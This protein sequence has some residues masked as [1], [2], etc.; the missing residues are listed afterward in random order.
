MKNILYCPKFANS[1]IQVATAHLTALQKQVPNGYRSPLSL[2]PLPP[3]YRQK[4]RKNEKCVYCKRWLNNPTVILICWRFQR[5]D[6]GLAGARSWLY[7]SSTFR[8]NTERTRKAAF[9]CVCVHASV[10]VYV[11]VC[12]CLLPST[13]LRF[14]GFTLTHTGNKKKK[15]TGLV[16]FQKKYDLYQ[17]LHESLSIATTKL[18]ILQQQVAMCC[19]T[20][21]A[22]FGGIG[23]QNKG[24][25]MGNQI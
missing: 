12:V 15:N 23:C 3:V 7:C 2:K 11:R 6:V 10:R 1:E 14:L 13:Q 18:P 25:Q 24:K 22:C 4:R 17:L 16:L 9:L 19:N 20:L 5:A 21:I 8:A